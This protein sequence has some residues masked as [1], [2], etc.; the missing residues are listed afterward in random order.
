VTPNIETP[1]HEYSCWGFTKW[2]MLLLML[3]LFVFGF[4]AGAAWEQSKPVIIR[5]ERR[6][7]HSPSR[8]ETRER[9]THV[10]HLSAM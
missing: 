6:K 10:R 3:C 5:I 2:Q 7:L 4:A 1:A 8:L 9:S